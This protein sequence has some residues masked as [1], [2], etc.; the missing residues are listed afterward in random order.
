[1]LQEKKMMNMKALGQ[2]Q[3]GCICVTT[4]KPVWLVQSEQRRMADHVWCL[5]LLQVTCRPSKVELPWD[6]SQR[7]GASSVPSFEWLI[8]AALLSRDSRTKLKVK[9]VFR[10][11]LR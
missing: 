5:E 6:A 10:R 4:R 2:E 1:M 11:L 7:S 9:R 8:L 3:G